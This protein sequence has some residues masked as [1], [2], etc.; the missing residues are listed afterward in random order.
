MSVLFSAVAQDSKLIEQVKKEGGKVIGY[1]SL[2]SFT[3]EPHCR[4]VERKTGITVEYWRASATKV[5]DRALSETR[6]GKTLF[7]VM[8]NNSGAMQVLKKEGISP[9]IIDPPPP[10]LKKSPTP[11]SDRGAIRG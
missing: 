10:F 7:D 9:D 6:A 3:V 8:L 4:S 1:G 11:I 2:E 5:M